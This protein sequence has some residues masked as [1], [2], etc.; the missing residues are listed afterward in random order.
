MCYNHLTNHLTKARLSELLDRKKMTFEE[1]AQLVEAPTH[2]LKAIEN[3]D[4]DPPLSLA[5]KIAAALQ[6][7][8]ERLFTD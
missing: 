4:Y 3:G 5:Y 8:V 6:I 7:P 1:F 2:T